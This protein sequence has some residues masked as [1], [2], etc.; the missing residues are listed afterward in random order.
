MGKENAVQ[1]KYDFALNEVIDL[2]RGKP[3]YLTIDLDVLGPS[4]FR[5]AGD[6]LSRR[7]SLLPT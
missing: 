7:S 2:L 3:V 4:I 6:T 5:G 1:R